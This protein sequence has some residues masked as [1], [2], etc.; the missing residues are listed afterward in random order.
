M[1]TQLQQ[2]QNEEFGSLEILMIDGKPYFPATECA[3]ILG[4]TNPQKAI[5]DHCKGVNESFTPSAGGIQKKKFLPEGDLYRLIIR[6]R[7]PSAERFEK[8]VFDEV[9]PSIRKHGAYLTDAVLDQVL[10][11][12]ELAFQL[13]QELRAEKEKT[14]ALLDKLEAAAPKARYYDLI[15]QSGNA[16]QVSVI[17]KDYGMT[18]VA[19]NR[20]LHCLGIQYKIGGTWLLYQ[21]YANEGY[22]KSRTYHIPSGTAVIHTHWT[23]NGRFFLYD[24]LLREGIAPL[25]ESDYLII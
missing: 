1:K 12:P 7:L 6:S 18:A 25:M 22:T 21:R 14:G 10:Q 13:F 24:T 4:Y 5:R 3:R 15:L 16:V 20:L 8:W 19:F 9:L 2:F 17:A 23:Q 11:S